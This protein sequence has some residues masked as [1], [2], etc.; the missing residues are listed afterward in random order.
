MGPRCRETDSEGPSR[1]LGTGESPPVVFIVG[2]PRTGSTILFQLITHRLRVRYPDKLTCR[3]AARGLAGLGFRIG[4]WLQNNDRGHGQFSSR[5]GHT[6]GFHLFAPDECGGLFGRH[7]P[8]DVDRAPRRPH[9]FRSAVRSRGRAR[10]P[11]VMKN[12]EADNWIPALARLL[13]ES[14]FIHIR[15]EWFF[16][17]QSILLARRAERISPERD[18]GPIPRRAPPRFVGEHERVAWQ[19]VE[20]DRQ[21]EADLSR[22]LPPERRVT[23]R[24]EELL[25]AP[26][27]LT[28]RLARFLSSPARRRRAGVPALERS[29]QRRRL[30]RA[31]A[32]R[33]TDALRWAA[34]DR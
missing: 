22:W 34:D 20:L 16:C 11:L 21:V 6:P 14:R 18:W 7:F 13:P 10:H 30:D 4:G 12:L 1:P 5:Y 27:A 26:A 19:I 31:D 23:V 8:R 29:S 15:R 33:L 9:A 17:G 24:Y 32:E 2:P 28:S 3:L 25:A